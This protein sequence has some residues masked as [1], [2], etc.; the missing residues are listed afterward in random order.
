[1]ILL[2]RLQRH[3]QRLVSIPCDIVYAG[4]SREGL[5]PSFLTPHTYTCSHPSIHQGCQH[6]PRQ[7]WVRAYPHFHFESLRACLMLCSSPSFELLPT[8]EKRSSSY[9]FEPHQRISKLIRFRVVHCPNTTGQISVYTSY[10]SP[11]TSIA[12]SELASLAD[13]PTTLSARAPSF[14]FGLVSLLRL[15]Q[16]FP[17]LS[18]F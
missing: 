17:A 11:S 16:T 15:G 2:V 8:G 5:V 1:M 3:L 9:V 13:D 14:S 10:E 7:P 4:Q 6:P 18:D 12:I